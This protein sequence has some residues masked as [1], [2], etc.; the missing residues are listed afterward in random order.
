MRGQVPNKSP[1]RRTRTLISEAGFTIVEVMTTVAI[2]GVVT[3]GLSTFFGDMFTMQKRGEVGNSLMQLRT[4]LQTAIAGTSA[5]PLNLSAWDRTIADQDATNGNPAMACVLNHTACTHGAFGP[6]NLKNRNGEELMYSGI[7]TRGF[8]LT[9]EIC[10]TFSMAGNPTCPFRYDLIWSATCTDG[11]IRANC[12]DPQIEVNGTL[13]YRPGANDLLG[14]QPLNTDQYNIKFRRGEGTPTNIPIIFSYTMNNANGEGNC[15]GGAA[16]K[17][18]NVST[19]P[20]VVATFAA[21]SFTLPQ[22]RY[23]CRVD[24]PAFKNGEN[25]VTLRIVSGATIATGKGIASIQGGATTISVQATL[26]LSSATTFEV[27]HRCTQQPTDNAFGIQ[28]NNFAMGA[29]VGTLGL[30]NSVTYTVVTCMKTG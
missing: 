7:A 13:L 12:V 14:G 28:D 20:G 24:A 10:N 1:K 26:T 8:T 2:A 25:T 29:P 27:F 23:E 22:G 16:R 6:L 15:N 4:S 11:A 9:G 30:Y 19:P 17:F 5:D 18:N 21:Q 3:L